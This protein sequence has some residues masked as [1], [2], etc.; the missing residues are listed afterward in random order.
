MIVHTY[1]IAG[2]PGGFTLYQP[3][4]GVWEGYDITLPDNIFCGYNRLDEPL[5]SLDGKV[6]AL[7]TVLSIWGGKPCL[8]W[9]NGAER[10]MMLE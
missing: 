6:Y 8:R 10:R 4:R 9:Y 7:T 5:V 3:D 1:H 2:N